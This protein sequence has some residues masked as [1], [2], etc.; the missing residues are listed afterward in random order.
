MVGSSF[1]D[2]E[3]AGGGPETLQQCVSLAKEKPNR[4]MSCV[5]R[6]VL[7]NRAPTNFCK[8][9]FGREGKHGQISAQV[10]RAECEQVNKVVMRSLFCFL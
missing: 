7:D 6:A 2:R 1:C 9:A 4:F 8:A 3:V 10:R 5:T